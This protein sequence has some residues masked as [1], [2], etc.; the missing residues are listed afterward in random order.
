[1]VVNLQ[2]SRPVPRSERSRKRVTVLGSTGSVGTQ[3]LDLLL[4]Q[5]EAYEVVALTANQN[6]ALLAQQA[7]QLQARHAVVASEGQYAALKEALAGSGIE[8]AAGAAAVEQ[9]AA[10]DSDWVMSAIV[11]AAGL[12]PTMAA[13]RRGAVVAFAN[14]E[15]LVCAGALMMELVAKTG[16]QLLP[17]DSE[18]NAIWQVFEQDRRD[19]VTRLILTA[20][21]G[22]FRDKTRQE[23]ANATA[24]EAVKHPVWTMGAKISID[25]ATMMNKGLEII[26][27][28]HLFSMPEEKIDIVVHPQSVIHSMVEYADGSV[29]AQLG[30]PDMRTPIG[31]ALAWPERMATPAARLDLVK[32]G[33]L[34]FEAPDPERFPCL[35]LARQA[36]RAGGTA[37]AV[38]N[39][40]NEVAVA[41]F[42]AGRI[43]FLD[44]ATI[45]ATT[46]EQLPAVPLRSL[47]QLVAI[48]GAARAAAESVFK[49]MA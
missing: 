21:G 9:A 46:L 1:M 38:L 7:R 23:M 8:A 49:A 12:A 27:A 15:T 43:G 13:V 14:K 29:L 26:E 32:I 11:G 25:S 20:S 2:Q 47:E 5:P 42:L 17:V 44:I 30:S 37:P 4:R 48:D 18:H 35:T 24:A 22:P 36:L 41:A 19:A 40:A 28:S 10:E 34:S 39:A 6:V 45:N 16:A 3:T 33:Q 31:Y